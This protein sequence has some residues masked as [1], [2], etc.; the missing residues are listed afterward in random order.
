MILYIYIYI[1]SVYVIHLLAL[2]NKH[3]NIIDVV[4]PTSF[5]NFDHT[6]LMIYSNCSIST[7]PIAFE[8]NKM[9]FALY[10]IAIQSHFLSFYNNQLQIHWQLIP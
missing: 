2:F 1:K 3:K 10:D 4:K 8:Y 7:I 5:I 9:Y 6:I